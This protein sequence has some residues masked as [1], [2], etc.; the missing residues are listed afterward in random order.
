VRLPHPEVPT[1]DAFFARFR[2]GIVGVHHRF[3]GPCGEQKLLYADWTASGRLYAPIERCL[4]ED[5]GPLV[6]N[7]HSESSTTGIAMTRAYQHAQSILKQHVHAAPDDVIITQGSGMT[8]VV[9][10]LQRML[11]L[12]LPEQLAPFCRLPPELRPVVFLTHMEHHSNHTSWLET[13][14]EVEVIPPDALGLVDVDALRERLAHY[15]ERPLKLGAF[16][17]CSNVTGVRTP[18]HSLARVMHEAGGYCFVDYAASAPYV[19]INM[20]PRDPLEK[21][22]AVY[23]SPHKFLGGPGSSGVLIF[24]SRLYHNRVPDQPGGGTVNWT[25]PWHQH[26]FVDNIEARED[27]G[28]PGFLQTIKAALAVRLKEAMGTARILEQEHALLGLLLGGLRT[29]PRLHLLADHLEDRLAIVSFYVEDVHYNLLVR[30]LNDRFGV[31]V[32]GGCSC[33]GTYG[34]YLLHVDPNRSNRITGKID[35]GD[36]SEKPGWVRISLHPTTTPAEVLALTEAV[37]SCAAHAEAW[38]KEYRYSAT[39]NEFR[40]ERD[41]ESGAAVEKLF[42]I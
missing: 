25:N 42:R 32:R 8:A 2:E 7:T 24:D 4:L 41:T 13:V 31:Q 39:T 14:A 23:F 27:G 1:L 6:G 20:H 30:L 3:D 29:V 17:G 18:V 15:R 19:D 5:L 38:G 21:L 28:T 37:R 36:L 9:N 16:T 12:R 22:D 34:H 11:G 33:A 35:R 40:H 26:S 10:K